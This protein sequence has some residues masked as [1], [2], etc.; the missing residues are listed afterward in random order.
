M[1]YEHRYLFVEILEGVLL[2]MLGVATML[3]TEQV[4]DSL[5]LIFGILAVITGLADVMF[6]P[7]VARFLTWQPELSATASAYVTAV[8][9]HPLVERWYAEAAA[10]PDA[11]LLDKYENPA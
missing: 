7:V 1:K 10:E 11:W 8:R 6:A 3:R 5:T 2:V 4:L 9:A